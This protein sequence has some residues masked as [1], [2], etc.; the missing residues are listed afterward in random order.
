MIKVGDKQIFFPIRFE[1][2]QYQIDGLNF[3]KN[4]IMTGKKFI[5]CNFSTG[6]GKSFMAVSMFTNFYK[7][8][9]NK[10][11]KFD[12]L[13]N[14]KVLQEQYLRDFDFIHNYK[15]RSNYYCD[16]FNC[17][18]AE[19]KELCKILKTPCDSCPYD[20]AK[21]KWINSEIG[22]T[23]FHLFNT[24]SLYQKDT[25]KRRDAN[26]LI[27]DEGH[28][29]ESVFSD[30]LSTKMSAKTLKKCGLPLKEIEKLD[31]KYISKIK[32]L[33][34]YVEFLDKILVSIL[35]NKKSQFESELKN[36]TS[37]KKTELSSY[38]QYIDGK[39]LSFSH[40]F[41]S[42][43]SNPSNIVLDVLVN[44]SEKM[45]SGI[46][47]VTQHIWIYE[48]IN[49]II[50][51]NYDHV[52]FM[53]ASILDKKM[54]SFINGLDEKLTSYYEIPTPFDVKNRKIFFIKIGKMNFNNKEETFE[55]Q[56]PW[57]KKILEKYKDSKGII[58]TTNYEITDWLKNNIMDERLLF[59]DTEDRHEILEKHL[60]SSTP[61]VLVS[62]SMMSGIDLKDNLARFQILLK[63]PYPN[64]SSNKIKGRQKTNPDWYSFKTIMDLIQTYGRAVRSDSDYADM[65]ILDS[66]FSDLLKY[67]SD[68]MPSY[69][70]DAIKVLNI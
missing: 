60:N 37:K 65:F 59:H 8:F 30:F 15:G 18:C 3:M 27:I 22:L 14:S 11:A 44:K 55:K 34:K 49:D 26:V 16:K 53:S 4:T 62:P 63:I 28:D 54:F 9:V 68:K 69:F 57:I 39:L 12:I 33:D 35:E 32:Y 56:V 38:I 46:E 45:Y 64:I 5:L 25:I 10:S 21:N 66:N 31:D 6:I 7:N 17:S 2:R 23:N 1:P 48:Y 52:V 43:K 36:A 40:L 58:H 42:Y 20:I 24:L 47:L 67:N 29:F 41:E 61:T 70:K 51:K 50:W 19:G 13:T